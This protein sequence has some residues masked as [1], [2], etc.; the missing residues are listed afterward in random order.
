MADVPDYDFSA[1]LGGAQF[2]R[3][4]EG[5]MARL[6]YTRYGKT[7]QTNAAEVASVLKDAAPL[8]VAEVAPYS[9]TR[10]QNYLPYHLPDALR[11]AAEAAKTAKPNFISLAAAYPSKMLSFKPSMPRLHT[12]VLEA[13][14]ELM[15]RGAIAFL[16]Q[17][18][19]PS[20]PG[21]PVRLALDVDFPVPYP[22]TLCMAAMLSW[23][24]T[25]IVADSV[26]GRHHVTGITVQ[27]PCHLVDTQSGLERGDPQ[28]YRGARG[29]SI[30]YFP[31]GLPDEGSRIH[32]IGNMALDPR[33]VP[34][35]CAWLI[36]MVLRHPTLF[37]ASTTYVMGVAK[38]HSIAVD[39]APDDVIPQLVRLLLAKKVFDLPTCLRLPGMAKPTDGKT[40]IS[41]TAY[42]PV[43]VV[44]Y[45][46]DRPCIQPRS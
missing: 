18:V 37:P 31:K 3:A 32:F 11:A 1:I 7:G 12:D 36:R 14:A 21:A 30:A 34:C 13:L 33:L 22:E 38:T 17:S 16:A 28:L 26:P 6:Y 2:R 39:G 4:V 15:E 41:M 25:M 9:Q 27:L 20:A 40:R 35:I 8:T 46:G 19:R 42:M 44:N 5:A 24:M 43:A 23:L 45:D 29:S 10:M